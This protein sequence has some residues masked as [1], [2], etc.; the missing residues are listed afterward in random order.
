MSEALSLFTPRRRAPFDGL[1]RLL[2]LRGDRGRT[3]RD[4][5]DGYEEARRDALWNARLPDRYPEIIVQ[6]NDAADVMAAVR[7]ARRENLRIA[8]RSGGHSWAGNHIREGGML[9]DVS[10]LQAVTIDK[11]RMTA[12]TGPG[13][14]GHE[15]VSMLGR[16]GLFFP[17]GH[18][19][20]VCVGGYLLQGGFGWNGRALGLA[21]ESV[22]GLDVVTADGALVHASPE[23]NADL[24]WAAR[25]SGPGFFGV[26]TN[27][28]LRVYPRPRVIGAAA[29]SFSLDELERVFGW[30][31]AVGPEVAPSVELQI[32][33]TRKADGVRGPGLLVMAPV[34]ADSLGQARQDVRF[35]TAG[36]LGRSAKRRIPFVPTGL[37]YMYR[38][39]MRHYPD[40]HRYAVD[41]MWT[42]ASFDQLLPGLER[43]AQTLP[44][45]PSHMLWMNWSPP[46]TRPSMAFSMEDSTYISL[47]SVWKNAADDA[48]FDAWPT[49]RMREMAPLASGCQLADENLGRRPAKFVA[50][51]NLARL[52]ELRQR[53]DPSGRFHPWMGRP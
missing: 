13:R 27:F 24:Y 28:H 4:G 32:I 37:G 15:L 48:K 44:P 40:R 33:M 51:A 10:R 30:A 3:F 26:V 19:K 2:S 29:Q 11:E 41:N 52:D 20:G 49:E 42:S 43:I 5:D 9:L 31:H 25:G 18:C 8:V 46:P 22:I 6:A 45:A 47:Y 1:A 50:D 7:L 36:A 39:V 12:T 53:H 21:C 35:L 23:Q 14:A 17:A 34:F 16:R 38:T